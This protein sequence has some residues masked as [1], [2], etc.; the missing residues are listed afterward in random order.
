[1]VLRLTLKVTCDVGK[2]LAEVIA[3]ANRFAPLVRGEFG[4]A[5]KL[6]PARLGALASFA[7]GRESGRARIRPGPPGCWGQRTTRWFVEIAQS[8]RRNTR[9]T[10]GSNP[11]PSCGRSGDA[12]DIPRKA[13]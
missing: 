10:E 3:P 5:S 2:R 4:F 8:G 6:H 12:P 7:I 9:G 1:M 11:A 13:A